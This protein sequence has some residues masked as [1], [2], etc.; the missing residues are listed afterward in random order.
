MLSAESR[1]ALLELARASIGQGLRDGRALDANPQTQPPALRAT[2]ASFVTLHHHGQLR[3]CIGHLEAS[4]PL[5]CN[6]AANAFSAAFRDPRFPPLSPAELGG[7]QIEI[8]VL[9]PSEPIRFTNEAQLIAALRPGVDGVI[10]TE[11][12]RR[13]TFLPSVWKQLPAAAD[14]LHHLKIKAGLSPDH[15]SDQIRAWRYRTESFGE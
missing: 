2:G 10:L 5:A 4:E 11:G 7:L 14:F 12:A 1:R 8:S 9:T 13:G 15:W 3:G 6:V